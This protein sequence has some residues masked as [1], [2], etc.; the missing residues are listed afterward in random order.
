MYELSCSPNIMRQSHVSSRRSVFRTTRRSSSIVQLAW[1]S[2]RCRPSYVSW[3]GTISA[4]SSL[5]T[6]ADDLS[7]LA[8]SLIRVVCGDASMSLPIV[9]GCDCRL[10]HNCHEGRLLLRCDRLDTAH[11]LL[12]SLVSYLLLWTWHV[13]IQAHPVAIVAIL[14]R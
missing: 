14:P 12:C 3:G 4:S 7:E 13:A 11:S 8:S 1:G 9:K 5:P 2:K 10:Q 6:W